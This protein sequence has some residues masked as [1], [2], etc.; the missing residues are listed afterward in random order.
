MTKEIQP[1]SPTLPQPKKGMP[2][3]ESDYLEALKK[4]KG[5]LHVAAKLVSLTYSSVYKARR[6]YPD[7]DKAVAEIKAEQDSLA[8]AK[9]EDISLPQAMKPGCVTERIFRMK[10]YDHK[11][12]EKTFQGPGN[13]TIILGH[14]IPR[15][16]EVQA[17]AKIIDA[18]VEEGEGHKT[19]GNG[20]MS[21]LSDDEV[22]IDV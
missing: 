16:D 10:A 21:I 20:K 7:L 17:G 9:L 18:D 1:V 5:V 4:A 11:Y 19:T 14:P 22:E 2:E 15:H 12:R 3:W 13:I 6:V 8:L